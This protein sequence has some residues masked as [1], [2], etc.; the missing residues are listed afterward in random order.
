MAKF[1]STLSCP[2]C[3]E[4]FVDPRT[5][6]CGNTYCFNCLNSITEEH[7]KCPICRD[8]N[9]EISDLSK[10][11]VLCELIEEVKR[12]GLLEKPQTEFPCVLHETCKQMAN[13]Y[14][15]KCE[16]YICNLCETIHRENPMSKNHPKLIEV[17]KI[18]LKKKCNS[19]DMNLDIFCS[20]CSLLVCASCCLLSHRNHQYSSVAAA[21]Q[22]ERSKTFSF[23]FF[24]GKE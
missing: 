4:V 17:S 19:H 1:A 5:L 6:I 2:V 11:Y 13:F 14:C 22:S 20:N 15:E 9:Y 12:G 3:F 21:I 24:W 18:N 16:V 10:N 23:P 7:K 8:R